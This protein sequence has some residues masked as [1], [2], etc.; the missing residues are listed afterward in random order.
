M[1]YN[2]SKQNRLTNY[3]PYILLLLG[4]AV[5]IYKLGTIPGGINQ[6]EAFAGYEAYSLLHSGI[7]SSGYPNPVYFISW[8]SGMN[9][10][11]S[12]LMIP[13]IKLFG[14]YTWVIRIPQ[15]LIT[16]ISLFVF[17]KLILKIFNKDIALMGLFLLTINP[18]HIMMS[19]WALESNLTPGFLLL[20]LYFFI[21][22]IDK[23][24]YLIAS[25]VFYG[26]SLYC[27]AT[28]WFIVPIIIIFQFIYLL[29]SHKLRFTK[30]L[31]LAGLLLFLLALPLL[32]FIL[33]NTG[34]MPEIKTDFISI[35]QLVHMRKRDFSLTNIS[36]KLYT[37]FE[38]IVFQ[39][40]GCIWNSVPTY[41][42]HYLFSLPFTI[43]GLGILLGKTY[44][45]VKNHIFNLQ[46]FITIQLICSLI[47]GLLIKVNINRINC[48]HLYT[49]ICTALGLYYFGKI[50]RQR[51]LYLILAIYLISFSAFQIYYYTDYKTNISKQF[52]EGLDDAV[53]YAMQTE[54][55]IHITDSI[56]YAKILF[57]SK[58][59]VNEYIRTVRYNN[60]PAKFLKVLQFGRFQFAHNMIPDNKTGSYIIEASEVSEFKDAGYQIKIFKNFIVA[61]KN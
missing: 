28:I 13:F 14:L 31:W 1:T 6:D 29:Y 25:T 33:I 26:L 16:C 36:Q 61:Y 45:A 11:N 18:W 19:R 3:L 22:G 20:G 47:L 38:I 43:L 35:P 53:K 34:N 41:G 2:Y 51:L 56:S 58:I 48:L 24:N 27:Y 32:L 37:L 9:V 49:I 12:Y 60:Y 10:L 42:M 59:P 39:T 21:L 52:Q 17:Y 7:D 54:G 44:S 40:D 55:T 15:V 46:V 23:P 30:Q 5:R 8:G 4:V 57:Y 50:L